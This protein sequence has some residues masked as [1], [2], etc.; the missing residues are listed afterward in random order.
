MAVFK[1]CHFCWFA[2][3]VINGEIWKRLGDALEKWV[4][5]KQRS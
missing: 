3:K 5:A 4:V 1:T 2:L